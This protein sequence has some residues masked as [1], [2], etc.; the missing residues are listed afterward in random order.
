[1]VGIRPGPGTSEAETLT[2]GPQRYL[3]ASGDT[4]QTTSFIDFDAQSASQVVNLRD[5]DHAADMHYHI[6]VTSNSTNSIAVQRKA[7]S[8]KTI[9]GEFVGQTLTGATSFTLFKEDG[10]VRLR[11]NGD[12]WAPY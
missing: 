3:T 4:D 12:N 9:S 1:M 10:T 6:R 8:T 5:E 11:P 2:H 7:G